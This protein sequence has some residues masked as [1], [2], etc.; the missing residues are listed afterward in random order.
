MP[1]RNAFTLVEVLVVVAIIALL[2]AILM[3]SLSLA[4]KRGQAAVCMSNVRQLGV[5]THMFAHTHKGLLVEYGLAHGGSV[6]EEKTWLN[7]LR[8]EYK[9]K[10]VARCPS[11]DSL[12]WE[13]PY[14]NPESDVDYYRRTSYG[15]NEYV[16]GRLDGYERYNRLDGIP[17]PATTILY[18]EMAQEGDYAVS[19]HVHPV[20]WQLNPEVEAAK[21]IELA[22]HVDKSNYVF[23]DGHSEP[24]TFEQTY[25]IHGRRR[26]G[27]RFVIDWGH[28]M[29]DPKVGY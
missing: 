16:T 14:H 24:A 9:S 28:N 5:A 12:R 15:V 19:D 7:T 3:P 17:R 23:A 1:R 27:P 13:Q 26:V 8:N 4:R 6:D 11:D 25:D 20:N 2:I 10:L 22:L 21:Q 18:C 29:Y